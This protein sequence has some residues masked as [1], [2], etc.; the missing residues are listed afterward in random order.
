MKR[1]VVH[2]KEIY[3]R[4]VIIYA[5]SPEEAKTAVIN[6]EGDYGEEGGCTNTQHP[7][8]WTVEEK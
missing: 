1:Y 6:G 8:T 5:Y 4:P 3:D 7:D 2:V